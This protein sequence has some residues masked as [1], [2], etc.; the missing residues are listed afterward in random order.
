MTPTRHPRNQ[1]GAPTLVVRLSLW[2]HDQ[3]QK[4]G[5]FS[6]L[7]L[8]FAFLVER[9]LQARR[10]FYRIFPRRVYRAPQLVL[11][12][13]N[14]F[15]GGTGKTPVVIGLV[16]ALVARGWRPGVISRGYGLNVGAS[17][18][19]SAEDDRAEAL[20]DEPALIARQTQ[21]PVSVH[22]NR[23]QAVLALLARHP[24]INLIVTD[25]GLQH[26]ALA[27]DMEIVVQDRRGLG[28]GRVMP[29]G[30]L[31]EA[32][33]R[34]G[35]ADA[36]ITNCPQDGLASVHAPVVTPG[37][38]PVIASVVTPIVSP[39]ITPAVT[40]V[41]GPLRQTDMTLRIVALRHLT[42][43]ET[44]SLEQFLARYGHQPLDAAAGIGMPERFF[45][46]LRQA[47][48]TLGQ[49]L[50]LKDHQRFD[51]TTFSELQAPQILITPKDAIK[52][53]ALRNPR[54]WVV[55]VNAVFSDPGF[56]DW[57]SQRLHALR[58]SASSE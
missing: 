57:V 17:P 21:V 41:V 24:E 3:W 29:A 58:L 27:R 31:R 52:C 20:G 44:I 40:P 45:K 23:K 36:L 30:P 4:P 32:A 18:R 13:G 1:P 8:P 19:L 14:I 56:T 6:M 2:L 15:V 33:S 26:L 54:L 38:P 48:I 53:E 47:G 11:V 12:V 10:A 37:V 43:G 7:M 34:L 49:T 46:S 25:D 22:P 9:V 42:D 39:V 35:Q 50:A 5:W 16:Q 55:E 28:N 51:R